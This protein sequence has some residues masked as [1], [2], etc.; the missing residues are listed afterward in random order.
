MTHPCAEH[1]ASCDHCALC[2]AGLCCASVSPAERARLESEYRRPYAA[3][4]AAIVAEAGTIPTLRELVRRDAERRRL[5]ASPPDWRTLLRPAPA[6]AQLL[7]D[8]RKEA[9]YVVVPRTTR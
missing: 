4:A 7:S 5:S 2:E 3:I 6:D 9:T 8:S 1:M